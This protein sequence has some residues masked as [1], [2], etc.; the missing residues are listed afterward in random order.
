MVDVFKVIT[1]LRS[2][3]E[4]LDEAI[5][6]L[7]RLEST[8]KRPRLRPP[9]E[10]ANH[11]GNGR[12]R[13]TKQALTKTKQSLKKKIQPADRAEG[14]GALAKGVNAGPAA[15]ELKLS[16]NPNSTE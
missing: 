14:K 9:F 12:P 11:D 13:P 10:F 6:C 3:L 15:R 2:A 4:D 16:A 7:E 8:W 5:A 1:D